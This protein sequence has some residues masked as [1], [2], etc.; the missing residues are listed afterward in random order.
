MGI[1]INNF[2][3]FNIPNLTTSTTQQGYVGQANTLERSPSQDKVELSSQNKEVK[4]YKKIALATSLIGA[5]A[6]AYAIFRGRKINKVVKELAE[7]KEKLVKS[8]EDFQNIAQELSENKDKITKL[9]TELAQNSENLAQQT[10]KLSTSEEELIKLKEFLKDIDISTP[11]G[12]QL[13]EAEYQKIIEELKDSKLGYDALNP[14][15]VVDLQDNLSFC[16]TIYK[17]SEITPFSKTSHIIDDLIDVDVLKERFIKNGELEISLPTTDKIKVAISET[18]S[19]KG[20]EI[21]NLGTFANT[22]FMLNYGKNVGWSDRK[23]ARDIL[24]NFY[25]GHGNTLDGVKIK[26]NKLPN[27][28]TKV[29]ISGKG[30]FDHENLQF[31]GTGTKKENPYNAGG[32]GEG[33]K[34]LVANLIGGEKASTVKFSSADW[35]LDFRGKNGILQ[36]KVSQLENAIDGNTFEFTTKDDGVVESII[37]A[38]NYFKHSKN[39]D[40]KTSTFACDE[41]SFDIM[42]K[43]KKGNIYLTQR[44]EACESGAWEG[45]LDGLNISFNRKPDL[46]KFKEITGKDF[47]EVRDRTNLSLEDIENLTRYFAHENMSDEDITK[48]IMST[49][50]HWKDLDPRKEEPIR[51]FLKG[52]LKDAKARRLGIDFDNEKIAYFGHGSNDVVQ[53]KLHECGYSIVPEEFSNVGMK[54]AVEVFDELSLHKALAPTE[55]EIKKLRLLE[56][57]TECVHGNINEELKKTLSNP[58]ISISKSFN[59]DGYGISGLVDDYIEDAQIR[60]IFDGRDNIWSRDIKNLDDDKFAKLKSRLEFLLTEDMKKLAEE[61]DSKKI[62]EFAKKLSKEDLFD[63]KTVEQAK[64]IEDF[65]LIT[66]EDVK[67]PRY[68]FDRHQEATSNTLGEAIIQ[69]E[70]YFERN[71]LGHWVDRE[72]LKNAEFN[73]I[74]ATWL[75]EI[76]HKSGG[77][78]EASFTYALTDLIRVLLS[79]DNKKNAITLEAIKKAYEQLS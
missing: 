49:K 79:T 78:G 7:N 41:F 67:K 24:Q 22:D 36:R 61:K 46:K 71:Y 76:C 13:V 20:K 64:K 62:A 65:C 42:P 59:K 66:N 15:K 16:N 44:F 23:I 28:E 50:E 70:G 5:G 75:H 11:Q 30:V 6:A 43:G 4:K 32:F 47:A 53:K 9:T 73:D 38:T 68:I 12:K 57:A 10:A 19:I 58:Q 37:E 54:S 55:T 74:L 48:A 8:Q 77:D 56:K 33:A 60:A 72:H 34:V 40:F 45:A 51:S 14:P 26:L 2:K 27:G 35:Q 3:D 18:A 1:D 63:T 31:L 52:L 29:V 21:E 17:S 39:P 25:D 69:R